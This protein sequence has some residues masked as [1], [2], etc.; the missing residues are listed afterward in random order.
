MPIFTVVVTTGTSTLKVL[1]CRSELSRCR[2]RHL[3]ST[4]SDCNHH[5]PAFEWI[6][7]VACRFEELGLPWSIVTSSS[8][9]T[10][11]YSKLPWQLLL[12]HLRDQPAPAFCQTAL[13]LLSAVFCHSFSSPHRP[14]HLVYNMEKDNVAVRDSSDSPSGESPVHNG[15]RHGSVSNKLEVR[16]LQQNL[17]AQLLLTLCAVSSRSQNQRGR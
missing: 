9:A 15:Y 11:I 14:T 3:I 8:C 4:L 5:L 10:A 1:I 7:H 12:R 2:D 17:V 13:K 16:Y 6:F